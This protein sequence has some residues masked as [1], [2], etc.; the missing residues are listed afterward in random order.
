MAAAGRQPHQPAEVRSSD[1]HH[2]R[3]VVAVDQQA[4][5]AAG[6]VG[7]GVKDAVERRGRRPLDRDAYRRSGCQSAHRSA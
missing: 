6:H 5:G 3:Y 4:F 2:L 1:R 7:E